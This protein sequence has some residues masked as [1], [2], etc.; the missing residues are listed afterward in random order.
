M[1]AHIHI[2]TDTQKCTHTHTHKHVHTHTELISF[3]HANVDFTAYTYRK[4][5]KQTGRQVGR[6]VHRE[7]DIISA[8][9]HPG[10]KKQIK[11][12]IGLMNKQYD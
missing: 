8:S 4:A 1:Y 6:Q 3:L 10:C 7:T 5:G 2:D 9:T 12:P 11:F